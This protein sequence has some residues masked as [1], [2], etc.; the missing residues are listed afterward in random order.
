MQLRQGADADEGSA[1]MMQRMRSDF[2]QEKVGC[3][4]G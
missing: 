1:V 3:D 2:R 4:K